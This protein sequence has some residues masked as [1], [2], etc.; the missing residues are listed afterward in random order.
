M[1]LLGSSANG[2]IPV[3]EQRDIGMT[4]IAFVFPLELFATVVAFLARDTL[5]ARRRPATVSFYRSSAGAAPTRPSRGSMRSSSAWK[6]SLASASS[7]DPTGSCRR[8]PR[9]VQVAG[10]VDSTSR[11]P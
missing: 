7:S 2:W 10:T 8:G 4:L 5:G 6:R 3:G 1:L 9:G 11:A